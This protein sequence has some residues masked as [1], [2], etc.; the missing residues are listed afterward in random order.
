MKNVPCLHCGRKFA[1]ENGR[2]QHGK[3][4]HRGKKNPRPVC[5]RE[6]SMADLVIAAQSA[7]ACGEPVEEWL[8]DMF[9]I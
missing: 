4:V 7:R 1:D 8:A 2:Y 3:T 6:E 5:E 9:D